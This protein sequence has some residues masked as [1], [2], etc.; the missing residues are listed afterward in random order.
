M[1]KEIFDLLQEYQDLFLALVAELKGIKG[2][3]GEMKI[4][5]RPDSC[6]M[7]HKLYRLNPRVKEKVKREIDKMLQ[8]G[9]IFLIDE[10]EWISPIVIQNRKDATKI[11]VCFDYR[12]LDNAQ[13]C[14]P[15]LTPFSDEVLDNVVGNKSYS[16]TDE[17]SGYHQV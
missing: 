15:F 4:V 8:A 13:V 11:K 12:N 1:T 14:D 5:L 3:I 17:F 9:I 16:F 10:A 2:D 6:P 7:K